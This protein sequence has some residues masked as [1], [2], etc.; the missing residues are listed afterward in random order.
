MLVVGLTGGIG[1]G[2]S[3]VRRMLANAG[4]TVIDADTLARELSDS[5]VGIIKAIKEE[6]GEE[7]YDEH[8]HL[9]RKALAQ[10][11]FNDRKKLEKLNGII[12]PRVIRAVERELEQ[13]QAQGEKIVVI[14][15]ALHYEINWNEAMDLMVVVNAPMEQRLVRVQQRDGVD[16]ASVRRRMAHQLPIEEKAQRADYVIQNDGDLHQLSTAVSKL[17]SWMYE[18]AEASR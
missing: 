6:F 11:V 2:K 1:C 12:H 4:I 3:E 9:R 17:V 10:I 7:M 5:N 8:L 14:D 16:E 15:A 18:R 13:R